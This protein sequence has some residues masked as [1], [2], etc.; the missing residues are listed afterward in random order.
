[1]KE[2]LGPRCP[3]R[4][5][6]IFVLMPKDVPVRIL[7]KDPVFDRLERQMDDLVERLLRRPTPAP[8]Q[9]AWAPRLDVYGTA[10]EY[11]AVL[12]L[13]GVEVDEVT[14]EIEG[15]EVGITGFRSPC[16]HPDGS[17]PLQLEIPFGPFE[18]RFVLPAVVDPSRATAEFKDG[19][20]T[21]HLPRLKQGPTRV[22]IAPTE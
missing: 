11:V 4:T 14:V 15:A 1:M 19:M 12:E 17:D 20:L 18:R 2:E 22:E 13:A 6:S 16:T 5:V 10:D 21:V 3:S 9:R 7:L 8:Y